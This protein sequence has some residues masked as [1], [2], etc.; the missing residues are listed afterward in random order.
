M[1]KEYF[2]VVCWIRPS[3]GFDVINM[4]SIKEK[5]NKVVEEDLLNEESHRVILDKVQDYFEKYEGLVVQT[6]VIESDEHLKEPKGRFTGEI[7]KKYPEA[8]IITYF[9]IPEKFV[10]V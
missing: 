1:S 4:N 5:F 8:E 10:S 9:K 6:L 2:A 3:S 7:R